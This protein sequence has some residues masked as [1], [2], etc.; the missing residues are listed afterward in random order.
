[1]M[2]TFPAFTQRLMTNSS[3][4]FEVGHDLSRLPTL[5]DWIEALSNT[6]A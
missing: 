4:G 5:G 3:R 1:M 2:P 6:A